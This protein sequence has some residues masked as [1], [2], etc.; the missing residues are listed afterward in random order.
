MTKSAG[1]ASHHDWSGAEQDDEAA[2]LAYIANLGSNRPCDWDSSTEDVLPVRIP[3][4]PGDVYAF[5]RITELCAECRA[6]IESGDA[7]AVAARLTWFGEEF[8]RLDAA[9]LLLQRYEGPIRN[10]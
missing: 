2:D 8:E 10:P 4:H 3:M 7:S 6:T 9:A 1:W 5:A